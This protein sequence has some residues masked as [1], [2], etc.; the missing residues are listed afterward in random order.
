MPYVCVCFAITQ[1]QAREIIARV[2]AA[3]P[4]DVL[5]A[6]SPDAT[7]CKGGRCGAELRP[8]IESHRQARVIPI[9]PAA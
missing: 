8:Y 7:I 5:Q 9:K 1:K 4:L 2:D 6:I 3:V